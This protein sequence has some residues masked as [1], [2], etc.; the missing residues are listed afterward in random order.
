MKKFLMVIGALFIFIILFFIYLSYGNSEYE[1]SSKRFVEDV[2]PVLLSN[3]NKKT[4]KKYSC[5][6]LEKVIDEN[7]S[8]EKLFKM[9][10]KL[11]KYES[12][13]NSKGIVYTSFG[14]KG[15]VIKANYSVFC[16]FSKGKVVA[17][18]R[19]VNRDS[20][21][22]ICAFNISYDATLIE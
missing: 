3:F 4:L 2:T 20:K 11:G 9:F 5:K 8:T 14:S 15:K 13:N 12:F 1:K 17:K 16:N 7:N 22:K 18:Y 21:W 10:E 19:I 6:E